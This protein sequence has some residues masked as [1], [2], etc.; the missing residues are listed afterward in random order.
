MIGDKKFYAE[1]N[2][3]RIYLSEK[4]RFT[5]NV[6]HREEDRMKMLDSWIEWFDGRG[7]NE[8]TRG[9]ETE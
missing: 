2:G 4:N 9:P 3:E 8:G 6:D 1:K 7:I 5:K